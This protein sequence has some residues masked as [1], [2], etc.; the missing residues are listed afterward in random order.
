MSRDIAF[1][2]TLR[3]CECLVASEIVPNFYFTVILGA[4]L[5]RARLVPG[6]EDVALSTLELDS[7]SL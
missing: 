2:V 3:A 7:L 1:S 5:S 4:F 6:L